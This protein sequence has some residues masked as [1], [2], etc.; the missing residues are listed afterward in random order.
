[1][2]SGT[3]TL[4]MPLP[5]A[6]TSNMVS[7]AAAIL[8]WS[9]EMN[10]SRVSGVGIREYDDDVKRRRLK[11]GFDVVEGKRAEW[12]VRFKACQCLNN[13]IADGIVLWK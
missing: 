8:T 7:R 5:S 6:T 12:N 10:I 1:M 11:L 4:V 9:D 3:G 13:P 2:L